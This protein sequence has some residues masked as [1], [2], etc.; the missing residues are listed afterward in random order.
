MAAAA[1]ERMIGLTMP[2]VSEEQARSLCCHLQYYRE[3]GRRQSRRLIVYLIWIPNRKIAG[4]VPQLSSRPVPRSAP[5]GSKRGDSRSR[6]RR[7]EL[8][9]PICVDRARARPPTPRSRRVCGS[10]L[11]PPTAGPRHGPGRR[12]VQSAGR[13]RVGTGFSR[14][15]REIKELQN[16][17]RFERK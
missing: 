17:W 13:E 3:V 1:R 5:P 4:G 12:G 9:T 6:L 8:R 11:R 2:Q 7:R 14:K 15:A 10:Q 16:P